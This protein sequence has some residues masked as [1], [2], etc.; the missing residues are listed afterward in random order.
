MDEKHKVAISVGDA[1]TYEGVLYRVKQV[2]DD[3]INLR[4][5][6]HILSIA[7]DG[8]DKITRIGVDTLSSMY[9][10]EMPEDLFIHDFVRNRRSGDVGCVVE[11]LGVNVRVS[12]LKEFPNNCFTS[13][14]YL[15]HVGHLTKLS[16]EDITLLC[17]CD[18]IRHRVN[19]QLFLTNNRQDKLSNP[20]RRYFSG[21]E[22]KSNEF[23]YSDAVPQK[24]S[25][26]TADLIKDEVRSL[27]K[28]QHREQQQFRKLQTTA[29]T[30]QNSNKEEID[31]SVT[32]IPKRR[33]SW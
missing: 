1:V 31:D 5:K 28:E 14:I 17:T 4:N 27:E 25:I 19:C 7:V 11:L 2:V 29:P 3:R 15:W 33:G 22:S 12:V 21:V 13:M 20:A 16:V 23:D 18:E 24:H 9:L 26:S 6:N 8:F 32:S 10:D 30:K